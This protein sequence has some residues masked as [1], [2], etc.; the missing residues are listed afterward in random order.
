[1]CSNHSFLVEKILLCTLSH[2][3]GDDVYATCVIRIFNT[4]E[5]KM[6]AIVTCLNVFALKQA[7]ILKLI[8]A[9]TSCSMKCKSLC[10]GVAIIAT[11][12]LKAWH[13]CY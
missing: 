12:V 7:L 10:C 2:F 5:Y 6:H 8:I 4:Y 11:L 1:M 3:Y 9:F 13:F